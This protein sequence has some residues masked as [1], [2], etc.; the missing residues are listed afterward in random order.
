[1]YE[2]L[3]LR[4]ALDPK[5]AGAIERVLTELYASIL[6]YL[7]RAKQHLARNIGGNVALRGVSDIN[8]N[9]II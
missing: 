6:M 1:M 7:A 4:G 2:A 3:Y 8:L 9:M 5:T